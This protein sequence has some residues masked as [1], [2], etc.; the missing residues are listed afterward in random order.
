MTAR[1]QGEPEQSTDTRV[2]VT[3][4]RDQRSPRFRS[5]RYTAEV[6]EV[7]R[8][9]TSLTLKPDDVKAEDQ[10]TKVRLMVRSRLK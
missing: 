1:D 4:E 7:V 2:I 8:V 5:S 10:D 3:V 9:G 6:E